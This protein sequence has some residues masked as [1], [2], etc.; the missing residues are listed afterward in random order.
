MSEFL[1]G[2]GFDGLLQYVENLPVLNVALESMP[3]VEITESLVATETHSAVCKEHWRARCRAST[4]TTL[5]A[6]VQCAA[7]E[8]GHVEKESRR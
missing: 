3:T 8:V 1:L 4:S 7:V 2:S 6:C 5:I